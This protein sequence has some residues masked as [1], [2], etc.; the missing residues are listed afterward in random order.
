MPRNTSGPFQYWSSF[1]FVTSFFSILVIYIFF[2]QLIIAKNNIMYFSSTNFIISILYYN[3]IR[4]KIIL[5]FFCLLYHI[6][7]VFKES[8]SVNVNTI[9]T[10]S[11]PHLDCLTINVARIRVIHR[12][13]LKLFIILELYVLIQQ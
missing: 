4:F 10:I 1:S 5:E 9:S 8:W 3:I 13:Q 7:A 2:N 11:S 6:F 12:Y